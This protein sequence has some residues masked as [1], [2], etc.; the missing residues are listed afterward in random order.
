MLRNHR[1]S[2]TSQ[3]VLVLIGGHGQGLLPYVWKIY[4]GVKYVLVIDAVKELDKIGSARLNARIKL[5]K[6]GVRHTAQTLCK[7]LPKAVQ[8]YFRVSAA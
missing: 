8:D 2:H 1:N 3:D 4:P 7:D 5:F 6:L